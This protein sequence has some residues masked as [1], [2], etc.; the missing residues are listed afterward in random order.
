M[1]S[2]LD[3]AFQYTPSF[4]TDVRATFARIRRDERAR[5]ET[6]ASEPAP[7]AAV[8]AARAREP[9]PAG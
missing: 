1:R 2:I 3:R 8:V 4:R 5:T 7:S 6:P 9:D